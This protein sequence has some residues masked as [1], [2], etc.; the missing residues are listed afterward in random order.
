[1]LYEGRRS[2][3][4]VVRKTIDT[5]AS[6]IRHLQQRFYQP[7]Q[8]PQLY[9]P[10]SADAL[11]FLT[12]VT[13]SFAPVHPLPSPALGFCTKYV[14]QSINKQRTSILCCSFTP[15]HKRVVTGAASGELT[16]WNALTFN[17]ETILQGH[18][19]A[20]RCMAWGGEGGSAVLATGDDSGIIKYWQVSM[21]NLKAIKAH[22]AVVRDVCF[23][24]HSA[25]SK[26]GSCSDDHTISIWDVEYSREEV[27][28]SGHGWDVKSLHWHPFA[29]AIATG[30]KDN[31]IRVWDARTGV[32][33][34][35]AARALHS[36]R[37][38]QGGDGRLL[39][40]HG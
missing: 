3:K 19:D 9:L 14:T 30:S 35:A 7:P 11:P 2:R 15:E 31:S 28:I 22:K 4:P 8:H 40:S 5:H 26:M 16:L 39:A 6:I 24:P 32:G 34:E 12:T 38:R 27:G 29:A 21:N 36:P 17:F 1:M 33:L 20:I 37:G 23:S 10:P 18:D 25:G 13:P